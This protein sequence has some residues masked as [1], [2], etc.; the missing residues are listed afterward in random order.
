MTLSV[1]YPGTAWTD[2]MVLATHRIYK[3]LASKDYN[4]IVFSA[5]YPDGREDDR[6]ESPAEWRTADSG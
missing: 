5:R 3:V 6:L 4:S 2:F 1:G